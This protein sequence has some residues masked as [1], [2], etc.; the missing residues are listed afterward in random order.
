MG[1]GG[2]PEASAS[3]HEEEGLPLFLRQLEKRVASVEAEALQESDFA[4]LYGAA[5][6]RKDLDEI[7][8]LEEKFEKRDRLNRIAPE[9][10]VWGKTFEAFMH[11]QINSNGFFGADARG[12]KT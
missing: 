9:K 2:N 5:Q 7:N 1:F 8:G 11:E 6:V 4:D 12:I 3:R 10:L